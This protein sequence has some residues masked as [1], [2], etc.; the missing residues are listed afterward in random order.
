MRKIAIGII[1]LLMFSLPITCSRNQDVTMGGKESV[2][3]Q[4]ERKILQRIAALEKEKNF[5]II[6]GDAELDFIKLPKEAKIWMGKTIHN[7]AGF[8]PM[9]VKYRN[10]NT[11]KVEVIFTATFGE[12]NGEIVS[13]GCSIVEIIYPNRP[14]YREARSK[15]TEMMRDGNRRLA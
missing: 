15:V 6:S 4:I 10:G 5:E 14:G 1:T 2:D 7:K 11:E 12:E 9:D 3:K 8:F 13:G